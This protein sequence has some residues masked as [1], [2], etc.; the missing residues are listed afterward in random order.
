[1]YIDIYFLPLFP[2]SQLR[3]RAQEGQDEDEDEFN[4]ADYLNTTRITKESMRRDRLKAN[5]ERNKV[6]EYIYMSVC[7]Y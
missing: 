5:K 4:E 7:I 1:M 2:I 3:P 6:E